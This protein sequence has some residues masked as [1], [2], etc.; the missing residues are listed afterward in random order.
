M[1]CPKK[2]DENIKRKGV[3]D[4]SEASFNTG[5]FSEMEAET[6]RYWGDKGRDG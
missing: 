1:V 6:R 4:R 5:P 3:V 2:E